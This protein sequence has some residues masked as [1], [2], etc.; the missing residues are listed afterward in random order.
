MRIGIV[1]LIIVIFSYGDDF[2]RIISSPTPEMQSNINNATQCSNPAPAKENLDSDFRYGCFCGKNY[3]NI[4]SKSGKSYRKL[5]RDERDKLIEKYY[6]IKPIDAIDKLCQKHDICYISTGRE[7]PI[8][9]DIL[10]DELKKLSNHFYEEA[11]DRDKKAKAMRCERLAYDIARVFKTVFTSRE[12]LSLTRMGIF[13]MINT[14]ITVVSKSIQ[15]GARG[16]ND[17][18]Q[19]PHPNERCSLP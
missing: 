5:D 7:D 12:N 6:K 14:P 19:Y 11:K 17:D 13:M 15:S 1:L 18:T 8:C 3:P 9:N 16:F 2:A 10:F 4:V